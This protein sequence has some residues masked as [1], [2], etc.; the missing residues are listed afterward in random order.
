M[1]TPIGLL[2]KKVILERLQDAFPDEDV[3][4]L[5]MATFKVLRTLEGREG[6][7]LGMLAEEVKDE[8]ERKRLRGKRGETLFPHAD[9]Q[10]ELTALDASAMM[11]GDQD[12]S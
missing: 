3:Y 2:E 7:T 11:P 4:A 12:P 1:Q 8:L 5:G 9:H 6:V 10:D